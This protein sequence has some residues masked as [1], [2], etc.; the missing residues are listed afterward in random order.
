VKAIGKRPS[1]VVRAILLSG[2]VTI[3]PDTG[4]SQRPTVR[5]QINIACARVGMALRHP[6][7]GILGLL[8]QPLLPLCVL[9]GLSAVS[10]FCS[11]VRSAGRSWAEGNSRQLLEYR[12]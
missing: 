10:R 5:G 1:S 4:Y 7:N 12:R 11:V 6:A 8:V 3:L 9:F 2:L